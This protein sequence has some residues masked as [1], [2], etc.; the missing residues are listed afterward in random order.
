MPMC[1]REEVEEARGARQESGEELGAE[2]LLPGRDLI[3]ADE[4]SCFA[5]EAQGCTRNDLLAVARK[6]AG[7]RGDGTRGAVVGLHVPSRR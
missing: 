4:P 2:H 6:Q 3:V 1:A 5:R 7:Q